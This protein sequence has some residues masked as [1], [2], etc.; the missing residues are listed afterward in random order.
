[1]SDKEYDPLQDSSDDENINSLP[2]NRYSGISVS[3][4]APQ[5]SLNAGL[6]IRQATNPIQFRFAPQGC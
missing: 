5:V 2:Q 6:P 1:M 3:S 4:Q